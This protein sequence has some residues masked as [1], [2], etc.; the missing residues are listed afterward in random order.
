MNE[1]YNNESP[2]FGFITCDL[3]IKSKSYTQN[4]ATFFS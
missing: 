3:L 4:E 1:Y 2:F